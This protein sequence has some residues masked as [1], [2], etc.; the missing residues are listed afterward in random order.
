MLLAEA[1]DMPVIDGVSGTYQVVLRDG[2]D[3]KASFVI[4]FADGRVAA[5]TPGAQR[6]PDMKVVMSTAVWVGF[7]LGDREPFGREMLNGEVRM[8]GEMDRGRPIRRLSMSRPFLAAIGRVH[9][10]TTY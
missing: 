2:D 1:A 10:R 5:V 6:D 7:C 3:D 9:A 8:L 4:R